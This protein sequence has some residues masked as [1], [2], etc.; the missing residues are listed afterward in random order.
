MKNKARGQPG[1]YRLHSIYDADT[2]GIRVPLSDGLSDK[3]EARREEHEE[4]QISPD[5]ARLW[6][7][8][9]LQGEGA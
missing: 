4:K 5:L 1:K 9:S 3:C 8:R 2:A 7:H 6:E